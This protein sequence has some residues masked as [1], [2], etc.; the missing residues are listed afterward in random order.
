MILQC[1]YEELEALKTGA[2]ALLARRGSESR[3][4]AAP[5]ENHAQVEALV[6]RLTGALSIRTLREQRLV[7]TAVD[8][9]VGHLRAEMEMLVTATHPASEGAVIAYFD[10]AHAFSVQ[11]RVREIGSEMSALIEVMTGEPATPEVAASFVF[12]D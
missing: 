3:A 11:H 1:S 5:P 2:D 9:V 12:P 8:A 6:P 4:V 10:F 7:Q